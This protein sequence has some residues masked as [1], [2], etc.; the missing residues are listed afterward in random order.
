MWNKRQCGAEEGSLL[1]G[2]CCCS[3]M[4]DH[5]YIFVGGLTAPLKGSESIKITRGTQPDDLSLSLLAVQCV[6]EE[7]IYIYH[8]VNHHRC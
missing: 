5:H 1:C 8:F 2:I 4:L 3:R 6:I 7:D